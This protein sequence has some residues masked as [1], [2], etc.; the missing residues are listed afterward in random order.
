MLAGT[1]AAWIE[2]P[3]PGT[4]RPRPQEI[5][6]AM[7][8]QSRLLPQVFPELPTLA[9]HAVSL[10]ARG[11]GGDFFDFLGTDGTRLD[12]ALGDVSGKGVPAA[13]MMAS[14]QAS[15]RS[16]A[17]VDGACLAGRLRS[18]NALF[19]ELTEPHH[20]TTLFVGEYDDAARRLR[21]ANCGH[22]AP[23]IHR[24]GSG[25][26]RLHATTTVLGM[27]AEW[28][29]GVADTSLGPGETLLVYSD[30]VTEARS[31]EGE[32]YGEQRLARLFAG[33]A[34]LPLTRLCDAILEDV[35]RFSGGRLLDDVTLVLARGRER[36]PARGGDPGC[37]NGTD[38]AP[39][40]DDRPGRD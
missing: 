18:V 31:R 16:H 33:S 34:H 37:E 40:G 14:L 30:G 19:V 20:Y 8:V 32:E 27:F 38:A 39:S 3:P 28:E 25:L 6:S 35:R 24:P 5:E 15:L 7:R 11:V 13:L 10:P 2:G 4:R 26:E 1:E 12:I 23:L 9:C 36:E 21:Y 29:C 17:S 22:L